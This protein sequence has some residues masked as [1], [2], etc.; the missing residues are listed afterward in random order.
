MR[1]AVIG[2]GYVGLVTGGCLASIGHEVVC[3]D[4]DEAKIDLLRKGKLPIFEPGLDTVVARAMHE[5]QL[6]FTVDVAAA[7]EASDVIFICVGT[8]PM[9]NGDADLS[10]IDQV[11]RLIGTVARSPKLVIERRALSRPRPARN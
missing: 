2:S 4:S 8:P 7:V 3:T 11:A 5:G 9:E 1:I 6:A 10:A